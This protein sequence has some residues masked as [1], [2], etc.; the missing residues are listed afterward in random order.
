MPKF[1]FDYT[2]YKGQWD[3]DRCAEPVAI[4]FGTSDFHGAP[5]WLLQGKDQQRD[6]AAREYAMR[7]MSN[8]RPSFTMYLVSKD[9]MRQVVTR[10]EEI[11]RYSKMRVV[12]ANPGALM[13]CVRLAQEC[14]KELSR[15]KT[16]DVPAPEKADGTQS[17]ETKAGE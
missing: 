13:E 1:Y 5:Q 8:V 7:D 4:R 14:L 10:L 6:G 2:N 3:A 15:D 12:D 17:A 11:A 9:S 16:N